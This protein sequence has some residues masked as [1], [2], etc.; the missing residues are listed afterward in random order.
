MLESVRH[1]NPGQTEFP[2]HSLR[3]LFSPQTSVSLSDFTW[4][5]EKAKFQNYRLCRINPW[6]QPLPKGLLRWWKVLHLSLTLSRTLTVS[7]EERRGVKAQL[8]TIPVQ[9]L[10]HSPGTGLSAAETLPLPFSALQSLDETWK[11]VKTEIFIEFD[12]LSSTTSTTSTKKKNPKSLGYSAQPWESGTNCRLHEQV[13]T[14]HLP[15]SEED[16]YCYGKLLFGKRAWEITN[17][18]LM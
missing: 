6:K 8:V 7:G 14:W 10:G 2:I 1:I 11:E 5:G 17:T 16:C 15:S 3:C 4:G 13:K 9:T 12:C 18:W